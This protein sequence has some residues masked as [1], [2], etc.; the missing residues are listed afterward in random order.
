MPTARALDRTTLVF[1]AALIVVTWLRVQA[2]IANPLD[3]YFE[4]AQ[5]WTWSR[6]L[7]WGYFTQPPLIG[8]TIAATTAFFG[9]AE[10]AVRLAAPLAHAVAALAAF[11]L[12][13]SIYG[14]WT[15]VWSGLGWLALPGIA[16][17]SNTIST[18]ALMLPLWTIA[19]FALWRLVNTR[20][21][22]WALWLG[23][24]VGIGF[25]AQYAMAY[26]PVCTVLAARWSPALRQ[27]LGGGRAIAATLIALVL[28]APNITWNIQHGFVTLQHVIASA[29]LTTADLFRFDDV[30]EFA[31]GQA[32]I[33][34]PIAFAALLWLLWRTLLRSA[35]LSAEDKFLLP[36]IWPPLVF[37]G[38][39]AFVSRAN[40]NWAAAAFPAALAWITGNLI[41]QRAGRRLLAAALISNVLIGAI[42]TVGPFTL[43]P[44]FTNRFKGVRTAR[45]WEETAREIAVRAAGR[46]GDAPFTA[47]LVD[48]RALFYELSYYWREARRAGAPLPPL[49]M[50][51]LRTRVDNAAELSDPMR[52][53]EG[54]RVL[55]AHM[56]PSYL[57]LV[58]GDFTVFR[59]VEHLTI[60]LGGDYTRDL[61]I[62]VGE[63]FAPAPRD[64]AFETRLRQHTPH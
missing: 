34:G 15:G 59:T 64:T 52:R 10:W 8:W 30:W 35:G 7:D 45:A 50:W 28:I 42:V 1:I 60:P 40:I 49:R 36:F 61:E 18:D 32:L 25:Q 16:W 57:P 55:V 12:G 13:R 9:D 27:S 11:A 26:F 23:V 24:A 54:A 6:A 51:V 62:S 53:E 17:S 63:G 56:T 3:L 46:T 39:L 41:A 44:A 31:S 33:F 21:W 19:L 38:L 14:A 37:V 58:A 29:R 2:L 48:D 5:Y 47:V 43:D 20:S 4:E 22:W